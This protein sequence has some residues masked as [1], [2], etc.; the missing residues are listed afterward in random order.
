MKPGVKILVW[1]LPAIMSAGSVSALEL[2]VT[3]LDGELSRGRLIQVMPEIVLAGTG[4]Q[5]EIAWADVLALRPLEVETASEAARDYPL[6]FE[7]SDGSA[8]GGRIERVTAE[9]IEVAFGM[10]KPES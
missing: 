7:L 6:Q 2:E 8:F 1:F 5:Y 3:R 4:E 9:G 10:G